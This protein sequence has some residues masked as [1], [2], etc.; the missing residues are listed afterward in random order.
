MVNPFERVTVASVSKHLAKVK[1]YN[2]LIV[3]FIEQNFF[4]FGPLF[5]HF[6]KKGYFVLGEKYYSGLACL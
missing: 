4:F 5:L 1:T 3:L 2:C 6:S